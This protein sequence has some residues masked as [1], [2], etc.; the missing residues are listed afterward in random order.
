MPYY[1]LV[2][3]IT[4]DLIYREGRLRYRGLG[5]PPSYAAAVLQGLGERVYVVTKHGP[6]LPK[7]WP[8]LQGLGR[9]SLAPNC[10][11]PNKPTTRFSLNYR[12]PRRALRLLSLCSPIDPGQLVQGPMDVVLVSPVMDE[13]SERAL[14][15]I[16]SR[17]HLCLLDPQGFLRRADAR[18]RCYLAPPSFNPL[19]FADYVK[20]DLEEARAL[21]GPMPPHEALERLTRMGPRS[22]IL[23]YRGG[24]YMA[25]GPA[26]YHLPL[27]RVAAEDPTGAGDI[28]C[29]AFV[30]S[31]TKKGDPLLALVSAAAY[32]QEALALGMGVHKALSIAKQGGLPQAG[33]KKL[34]GLLQRLK[35][36]R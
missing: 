10:L 25:L 15:I 11:E 30:W 4:L 8:L 26:R 35:R 22:A 23:T 17:A 2:G 27:P 20:L 33:A 16:R 9:M 18:G 6:S 32:A 24:A 19:R 5:G 29:A 12:G 1:T 7:E 31:L 3:H 28:F 13:L 34:E 36:L 14:A 21:L